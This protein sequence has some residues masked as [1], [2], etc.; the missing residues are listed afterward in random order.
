M[1]QPTPPDARFND[2]SA[3]FPLERT[4]VELVAEHAV[5]TP[6]A[7][8]VDDGR[9][10]LTYRELDARA[11]RLAHVLSAH[12]AGDER[13]VAICVG[14]STEMV[15]GAL[16]TLKAGSA[17]VPI[18]PDYPQERI[19]LILQDTDPVAV[20]VDETTPQEVLRSAAERAI[21]LS[22]EPEEHDA[23]GRTADV[24]PP[25]PAGPRNLAYV[26]YTSGSTGRPKGVEVEHRSLVNLTHALALDCGSTAADRFAQTASPA[27]DAT[28]MEIWHPLV[29]GA[30]LHIAPRPLRRDPRALVEW[31]A[32]QEITVTMVA[33]AL[34]AMLF[35]RGELYRRL[36]RMRWLSTG[37]AALLTRPAADTPYPLV[38]MY[39]P[40]ETTVVAT[41][42]IVPPVG[43]APPTIGRPLANTLIHILGPEREQLP[44]GARGEIWI[45]GAQVARG[46]RGRPDL[47]AERFVV[48][49]YARGTSGV[50]GAGAGGA[51]DVPRMYRTGDVGCWR[52]DGE[53]EFHG[54]A[55]DQI[56]LRGYR[57]EPQEVEAALTS[58][59]AIVDAV[60]VAVQHGRRGHQLAA[61][62]TATEPPPAVA[63]VR[64]HARSILPQYMVPTT[65]TRVARFELT[66]NGKIDRRALPAPTLRRVDLD[67]DYV[68]PRTAREERCAELFAQLLE[69]D[70]V[71]IEDD[72]F[73][74]GGDSLDAVECV[75]ALS[76]ELG[77][78]LPVQQLYHAPTIAQLL[79]AVDGDGERA[80]AIDWAAEME[81]RLGEVAAVQ[82][83]AAATGAAVETAGAAE[84]RGAAGAARGA[85]SVLLTGASGFLGPHL[86]AELA[87]AT[88]AE[89]G[90]VFA[91][92][93]APSAAAGAQ[94]LQRSLLAE[95]RDLSA[96]WER[97]VVLPG[98]LAQPRFGLTE[99]AFVQ[100]AG[101]LDA[102]V[103]SGAMVHHLYDYGRLRAANV[104]GTRTALRLAKL[105][106]G[107]PLRYVS[108]ISTAL[109][110]ER[111]R[112][113]ERADVATTPPEGG[114]YAETKW[115][116]ERMV[117]KAAAEG[118]PTEV[119]RL[120][121]AMGAEHSGATS[122]HDAAV[123]LIR[124]C[125][126]LGAYPQ[127]NGWEPWAPVDDLAV[128]LAHDPFGVGAAQA[129]VAPEDTAAVGVAPADTAPAGAGAVV[130]PP[131]AIAPFATVL[132]AVA[133][134]GFE[135]ESL[136]LAAWR[137]RLHAAGATNAA[138]AVFAEFG[139]DADGGPQLGG[140]VPAG[141]Q[142]DLTPRLPGPD[143]PP[144]DAQ[145]VW[146]MLDY[147]VSVG[148]LP[149]AG[150]VAA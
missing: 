123:R 140:D 107:I 138:A 124:G 62:Y 121:R 35:G 77:R 32:Q 31:M 70:A 49:P 65:F 52:E 26:V 113:V 13:C 5:A 43:D 68:A 28:V 48:D 73:A 33:T 69:L 74:L 137:Q 55:D 66:P 81:P 82:R 135:L 89:G 40:T 143:S 7:L 18:D 122:T 41:Q 30:S 38:N 103:H 42:G 19:A 126:E 101:E 8:A 51:A 91:L 23:A 46:Y 98:D 47:T 136:P 146:R 145:Y 128:A 29:A 120:P 25:H 105:A 85:R 130:Y 117:L 44:L 59:P 71:G 15:L 16:A 12:G 141:R 24:P 97:I 64:A 114:G 150:A 80:A 67:G 87:A 93:R 22:A 131:A 34:V 110:F 2:D 119:V 1:P 92:V 94:R 147:L 149:Q 27:F 45:G 132:R 88:R 36:P 102:I 109:E 76:D 57:I 100:L 21:H 139:L 54:R 116:A 17:Y 134:Y 95:R 14:A 78:E 127:W 58:L 104:E 79:A 99:A 53:L 125:M 112:L 11:N 9:S 86:L 129:D 60:V 37:G 108:S 144:V 142:W 72:F 10:R 111:G 4:V 50:D 133:A 75:G 6:E 83:V 148:Y 90:R 96:D 115:V 106:G 3:A 56:E 63:E 84:A 61:Y 39:G 20:L 118:V